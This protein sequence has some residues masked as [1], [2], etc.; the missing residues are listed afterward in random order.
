MRRES[1]PETPRVVVERASCVGPCAE[2]RL[3]TGAWAGG[4]DGLRRLGGWAGARAPASGF[5]KGKGAATM[6]LGFIL[7]LTVFAVAAGCGSSSP[8]GATPADGG[9]PQQGDDGTDAGAPDTGPDPHEIYP[10]SHPPI[11]QIRYFGG[12]VLKSPKIVTVTL[13]GM[14]PTIRDYVI[15]FGAKI[16]AS[17]YW[18]TVMDGYGVGAATDGDHRELPD[19][20]SNV[21]MS[22]SDLRT[23]FATEIGKGTLPYPDDDTVYMLYIP[24][25]TTITI[26]NP[27]GKNCSGYGGYHNSGQVAKPGDD[28]GTQTF[29]YAVMAECEGLISGVTDQDIMDEETEIATHELAEAATDPDV[30]FGKPGYYMDNNDAWAPNQRG[31]EVGDLCEASPGTRE[32]NW[33]VQTIWNAASAKASHAPCL[34][35]N[36]PVFYGAVPHT[37]VPGQKFGGAPLVDGYIVAQKNNTTDVQVDVFSTG[38]MPAP[39]TIIATKNRYG[40]GATFDPYKVS[41]VAKGV[42]MTFSQPTAR[43][44]D[45]LTLH[46]AVDNTA[47][48]GTTSFKVR[49]LVSK[50]DYYS[51][52]VLLYI[53]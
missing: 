17:N 39:L 7:G 19:T 4:G 30:A 2:I 16:G 46:I 26:D 35:A 31:G 22:D 43:N 42:T 12:R 44:G 13:A 32:G 9:A 50:T 28:A 52:P 37:V 27:P 34:P 11:P 45:K 47:V 10:A 49:A 6:R 36:N 20:F 18:K 14:N 15:D 29:V 3:P 23:W 48:S 51:W 40:G 33:A 21:T 38:P 8:N 24:Q 5:G 1:S 53:P 25:A 41:Q